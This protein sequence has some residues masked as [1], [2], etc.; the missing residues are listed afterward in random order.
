MSFNEYTAH[1]YY[2]PDGTYF[3]Y[4]SIIDE[5]NLYRDI[6]FWGSPINISDI[7]LRRFS[8]YENS[9]LKEVENIEDFDLYIEDSNEDNAGFD[10]L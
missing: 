10:N 2:T 3:V 9:N 8:V 5:R 7:K 4:G 6:D 1:G